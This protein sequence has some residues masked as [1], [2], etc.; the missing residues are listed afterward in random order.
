MLKQIWNLLSRCTRREEESDEREA[1]LQLKNDQGIHEVTI[2]CNHIEEARV[3]LNN[4]ICIPCI[5]I[6]WEDRMAKQVIGESAD[7]PEVKPLLSN[8]MDIINSP[9]QE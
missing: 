9:S 1:L 2:R 3:Y 8:E 6:E 4:Y 7:I 5:D